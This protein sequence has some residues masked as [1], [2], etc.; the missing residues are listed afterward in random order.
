MRIIA[1]IEARLAWMLLFE[2]EEGFL[3]EP[4][5]DYGSMLDQMEAAELL[6]LMRQIQVRLQTLGVEEKTGMKPRKLFIDA[7]Y[8]IR[9]DDPSGM[10]LPLR[11]LVKSLF[12]LF[13]KH[14]EGIILKQRDEY[15]QELEDIYGVIAPSVSLEDVR[16]RIRRIVDLADNSFSEKA[17]VLNARL[18]SLLGREQAV[19]YKI[20]GANGHPRCIPLDP[21]LVTWE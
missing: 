21:L 17:S 1:G 19:N 10:E 14:P 9:F 12:I 20:T 7:H 18:E 15:R 8:I 5:A 13:L 6:S 2:A 3:K 16:K 4:S 11:P